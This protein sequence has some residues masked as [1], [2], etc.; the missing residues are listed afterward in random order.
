MFLEGGVAVVLHGVIRLTVDLDLYVN[1][2]E[3]NLIKFITALESLG[4]RPKVPVKGM[5]FV[6]ISNRELWKKEKGMKVFSFIHLDKPRELIDVFI[7]EIIDFNLVDSEKVIIESYDLKIPI[8]SIK[9]LK[10]LKSIAG[11][12][13]DLSDIKALDTVQKLREV[14]G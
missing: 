7:D 8:M 10:E 3:D 6:N 13:Q 12:E 1:L 11:R 9:H 4:Y 14:K 2:S 5:D